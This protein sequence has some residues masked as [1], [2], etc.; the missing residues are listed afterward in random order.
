MELLDLSMSEILTKLN[1][2]EVTS[3]ELVKL[4]QKRIEETKDLNA[5]IS[6]CFDTALEQAKIIDSKRAKGEKV[7][8]LAGVPMV[9]KDNINILG[10][11]TTCASKFLSN[12]TSIYTATCVKKLLDAGVV[13]IGKAN[14][15]EFAMGSSNENSAFGPVKNPIDK[16]RVPGGSSGGSVCSVASKQCFASLGTET[17]G[18]VR[19]PASFCGVVGLKPT[20][21][22]VSRYGVVA[23]ASS[24]DQVGPV[25]R[26]VE[27]NARILSVIAGKDEMDM[28][29]ANVAVPNY[30]ANINKGVKGI[31]IGVAKQ[32]FSDKLDGEVRSKLDD[33]IAWY[34][35]NGAQI[36]DVDL[37]SIDAALAVYYVLSSAEAASN[38]ARFDGIRYGVRADKYDDIIDLYFKSR[39]QGFGKEVKRRIMLG[40]YVLS[41]GYYDAFYR[42]A[43]RV[44]KVIKHE[45]IEAFKHC[46]VLLSPTTSTTAFKLGEKSND[47]VAMYL[48]D[49]FTVPINIAGVPSLSIPCGVDKQGLPVGMQ[50]IGAHFEEAKIYQVAAAFEKHNTKGEK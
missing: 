23:F 46:D 3:V 12:Y 14:M 6:T 19:E 50:I 27:D 48:S 30:L 25:T 5:L 44:Q 29:S 32:F 45:F 16:T 11:K 40:N 8:E 41:S 31:K 2:K 39:T 33:A 24:L 43:K 35:A 49:V 18:S 10:T 36:V 34:Q 28:T 17:G 26:T 4:C 38:L 9:I 13:V 20:Y 22:R 15:D 7:G 42:K 1:N 37:P 47:P 21:G